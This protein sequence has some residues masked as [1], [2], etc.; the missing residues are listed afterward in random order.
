VALDLDQ[1]TLLALVDRL[2][3]KRGGN[4]GRTPV[5]V[6]T[7]RSI[8]DHADAH[9]TESVLDPLRERPDFSFS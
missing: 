8:R 5:A 2:V 6:P 1:A 9:R 7:E 4:V 3:K